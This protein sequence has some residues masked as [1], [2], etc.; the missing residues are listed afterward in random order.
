MKTNAA[1][2]SLLRIRAIALCLALVGMAG[3]AFTSGGFLAARFGQNTVCR[4]DCP[5]M[6]NVNLGELMAAAR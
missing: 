1:A 5:P 6:P 3:T 4:T 2:R